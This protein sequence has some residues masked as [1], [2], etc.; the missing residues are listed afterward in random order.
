MAVGVS[1]TAKAVTASDGGHS[2]H[3]SSRKNSLEVGEV[4][5]RVML[6][7]LADRRLQW[8]SRQ[9]GLTCHAR[10]AQSSTA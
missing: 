8:V 10:T 1:E 4:S 3:H 2:E 9:W 6:Q 7:D 5:A